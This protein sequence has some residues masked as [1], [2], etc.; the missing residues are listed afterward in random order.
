MW[1]F[2]RKPT[3]EETYAQR[4]YDGLVAHNEIGNITALSLRIPTTLH[5]AYQNKILLQ[6]ELICFFALM[7]AAKPETRLQP[8]MLA[9]GD[10]LISKLGVRG[11]QMNRDQLGEHAQADAASMLQSPFPWAQRWLAEFRDDPT[12]NFMVALFADHCVRFFNACKTGI[13]NTQPK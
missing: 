5:Q 12:D 10:L 3:W 6:R 8:V 11:I 9:F 7:V 1:P 2:K 4:I 13:E